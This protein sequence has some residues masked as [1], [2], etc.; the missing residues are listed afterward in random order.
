MPVATWRPTPTGQDIRLDSPE[1]RSIPDS[2]NETGPRDLVDLFYEA[3]PKQRERLVEDVRSGRVTESDLGVHTYDL[4]EPLRNA[5]FEAS[6][7]GADQGS[8]RANAQRRMVGN[9]LGAGQ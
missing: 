6:R 2:Q 7:V 9:R 8:I 5:L 1:P 3:D 4:P